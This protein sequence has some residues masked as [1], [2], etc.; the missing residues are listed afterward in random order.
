MR[1]SVVQSTSLWH[2]GIA[3]SSQSLLVATVQD[4]PPGC[5]ITAGPATKLWGRDHASVGRMPVAKGRIIWWSGWVTHDPACPATAHQSLT[6]NYV[7]GG[8][9]SDQWHALARPTP[10]Q[11]TTWMPISGHYQ[12]PTGDVTTGGISLTINQATTGNCTWWI[13]SDQGGIIG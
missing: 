2:P 3:T 10:A 9:A 13:V 1:A 12:E 5:P 6:I 8:A 11:A 7:R 4:A